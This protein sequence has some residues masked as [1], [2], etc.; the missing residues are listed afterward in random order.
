[1]VV[2]QHEGHLMHSW[3]ERGSFVVESISNVR[4]LEIKEN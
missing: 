4:K 1:M 3:V 2:T